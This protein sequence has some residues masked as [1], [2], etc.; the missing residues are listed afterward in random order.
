VA[1][2]K[3]AQKQPS[4]RE[5]SVD[6]IDRTI[7]ALIARLD[8][9]HCPESLPKALVEL[10]SLRQGVKELPDEVDSKLRELRREISE[11]QGQVS[12]LEKKVA[13]IHRALP[14]TRRRPSPHQNNLG[15][16]IA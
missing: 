14:E 7:D 2:R 16:P 4:E 12:E 5:K 9:P 6:S 10:I 15:R 8:Q 1:T 13:L 11:G 3:K